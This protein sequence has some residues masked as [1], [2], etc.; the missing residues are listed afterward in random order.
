MVFTRLVK[1]KAKNVYVMISPRKLRPH[2]RNEILF[3]A[4]NTNYEQLRQSII[5]NGFLEHNPIVCCKTKEGYTIICGHRRWKIAIELSLTEI[6]MIVKQIPDDDIE[7]YLIED[8]LKR[9][10]EARSYSHLERF[11]MAL[12]LRALRQNKRGGDRRSPDFYAIDSRH[13]W[14]NEI[15]ETVGMG[16]TYL[17]YYSVVARKI[18]TELMNNYSEILLGK[19]PH[20]QLRIALEKKFS[21]ELTDL[22]GGKISIEKLYQK[23]RTQKNNAFKKSD[24]QDTKV[25]QSGT[26]NFDATIQNCPDAEVQTIPI[27]A[28]TASA[29]KTSTFTEI[30][31]ICKALNAIEV[32]ALPHESIKM[33]RKTID[34][35]KKKI[36]EIKKA[37]NTEN[38]EKKE[39]TLPLFA[40]KTGL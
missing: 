31:D 11:I 34:I 24:G 35:L 39:L 15:S 12:Q 33:L 17:R 25:I 38:K 22:A 28:S 32:A 14:K 6:P 13:P 10:Q 4:N 9:A 29:S 18:L 27:Q 3:G 1:T 2:P 23:Y 7:R 16:A 8:N 21:T 20:D 30:N 37:S 26:A 19:E 36:Q 40:V 5:L